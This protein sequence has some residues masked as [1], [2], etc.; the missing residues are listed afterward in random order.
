MNKYEK[1]QLEWMIEHNCSIDVFVGK[2][3]EIWEKL[4]EEN[5]AEENGEIVDVRTA[6]EVLYDSFDFLPKEE[7]WEKYEKDLETLEDCFEFEILKDHFDKKTLIEFEET[8][9]DWDKGIID[10]DKET[11][12]LYHKEGKSFCR[13]I[14]LWESG[15][16]STE[17][18]INFFK[19]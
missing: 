1:W 3:Q 6:Y 17:D 18:L 14:I 11:L 7:E 12:E 13:D 4:N 9:Q 2:L 19:Y 8:L 5:K 16:I 15:N 10:F